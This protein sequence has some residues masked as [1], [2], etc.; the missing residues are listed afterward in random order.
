LGAAGDQ[1]LPETAGATPGSFTVSADAGLASISVGGTTV[2]EA[3]LGNLGATPVTIDTGEGSLVLTGY[4]AGTGVVSYTYDPAVQTNNGD[5]TDSIPVVVTD[6]LGASNSDT[7]DIVITDS[8]PTLVDDANSISEDAVPNTVSGNVVTNDTASADVNATPITA[9]TPT[10]TYGSLVLNSDGSYIYTLDN[11][12]ASVNAL[13]RIP[14]LTLIR[15]VMVR[16][17]RRT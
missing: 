9:A 13:D 4:D 12:N 10:L 16:P 3:Q 1:T 5:V 7:L 8:A 17:L 6:D 14:S 15:M 11:G 2:T